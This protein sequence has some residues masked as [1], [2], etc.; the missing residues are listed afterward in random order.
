MVAH[1]RGGHWAA[2]FFGGLSSSKGKKGKKGRV[3]DKKESKPVDQR[4][5]HSLDMLSAFASLKVW[6]RQRRGRALF[7]G[8]VQFRL[9]VHDGFGM[10]HRLLCCMSVL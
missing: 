10:W 3:A 1:A 6:R 9:M 4:L 2:G 8:M 7:L 5:T